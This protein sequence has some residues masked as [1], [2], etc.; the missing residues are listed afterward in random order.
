LLAAQ[1]TPP[2]NIDNCTC[3]KGSKPLP[4]LRFA[5]LPE[6]GPAKADVCSLAPESRRDKWVAYGVRNRLNRPISVTWIDASLFFGHF[7]GGGQLADYTGAGTL[8]SAEEVK[9]DKSNVLLETSSHTLTSAWV[10][11]D[12]ARVDSRE[13]WLCNENDHRISIMA[14]RTSAKNATLAKDSPPPT[15]DETKYSLM[16]ATGENMIV[17]TPLRPWLDSLKLPSGWTRES[18]VSLK[19]LGIAQPWSYRRTAI[20]AAIGIT[21]GGLAQASGGPKWSTGAGA[22]VGLLFDVD[23]QLIR[24]MR[25]R[26][27]LRRWLGPADGNKYAVLRNGS[28]QDTIA[29][30][31][32]EKG[33]PPTGKILL[34]E[35]GSSVFAGTELT[36]P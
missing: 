36:V 10:I 28:G 20:T 14:L 3:N 35:R 24:H 34:F 13:T 12:K 5:T 2:P 29:F 15:K 4:E 25:E 7:H 1:E 16:L 19:A 32:T 6:S 11:Q 9:D 23:A 27:V 26:G 30:S 22:G 8:R 18:S 21:A 17:S 33:V 31:Q